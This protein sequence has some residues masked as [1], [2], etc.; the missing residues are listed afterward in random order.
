MIFRNFV[1]TAVMAALLAVLCGSAQANTSGHARSENTGWANFNPTGGGDTHTYALFAPAGVLGCNLSFSIEGNRLI[2]RKPFD[3]ERKNSCR[4]WIQIHD[5]HGNLKTCHFDVTVTDVSEAPSDIELRDSDGVREDSPAGTAVETLVARDD[6]TGDGHTYELV[7]G[8]GGTDNALFAIEGDT[9]RTTSAFDYEAGAVRSVLVRTTDSTG[10]SLTK[11][12]SVDILDID[13]AAVISR[14]GDLGTDDEVA[15]TGEFLVSDQDTDLSA[16]RF[17]AASDNHDLVPEENIRFGGSG[18]SRSVILTPVTGMSGPR[19]GTANVTVFVSDGTTTAQTGFALT[20]TTGP[21]LRA[22]ARIESKSGSTAAPG[23][24]LHCTAEISNTG[25]RDAE[26]VRF[27]L[28]LPG[29]TEYLADTAGA[30]IRSAL[31][32]SE[33][34]P[35]LCMTVSRISLSG[36]VTSGRVK[37]RKYPLT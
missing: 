6:D 11:Q 34:P 14:I 4:I 7:S 37:V 21:E 27:V 36:S 12:L 16:L 3:Y 35:H 22:E 25:D 1:K 28:P 20:V 17:S 32:N 26:G 2:T 15:A 29:N 9:L 19:S 8:D 5:A 31:R 33:S 30:V 23:G 13:D 18:E 10:Q 24:I